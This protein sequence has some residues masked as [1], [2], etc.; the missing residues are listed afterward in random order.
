MYIVDIKA[1]QATEDILTMHSSHHRQRRCKRPK[2]SKQ[3][4]SE[5]HDIGLNM[6]TVKKLCAQVEKIGYFG[7]ARHAWGCDDRNVDPAHQVSVKIWFYHVLVRRHFSSA[8]V[9]LLRLFIIFW[10]IG[11]DPKPSQTNSG[12]WFFVVAPAYRGSG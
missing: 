6:T 2:V 12:Q 8:F 3:T 9:E 7:P 4:R 1:I 5:Q 11:Q 10:G